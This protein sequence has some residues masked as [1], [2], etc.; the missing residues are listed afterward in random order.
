MTGSMSQIL[1]RVAQLNEQS[2]AA[3]TEAQAHAIDEAMLLCK[4]P[5]AETQRLHGLLELQQQR[6]VNQG[7]LS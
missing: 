5:Q 6:L 1:A 2:A 7:W 3:R 4:S